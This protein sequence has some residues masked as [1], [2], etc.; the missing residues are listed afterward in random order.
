M[1]LLQRQQHWQ[2]AVLGVAVIVATLVGGMIQAG[3]IGR[4]W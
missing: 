2:L 3:W 1:V 4:P